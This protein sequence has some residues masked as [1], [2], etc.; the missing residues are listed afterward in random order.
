MA[1]A[2]MR[3]LL[4]A[5]IHFGHQTRRWHPKMQRFIFGQR[6]G[7]YI[8]DLQ[9]TLRR[10]Y[11]SYAL[12][13]DTVADGGTVLFV[14][15]KKQ[16]QEP[17]EREAKRC[18]MYFMTNRWLGGTLTN[19]QTVQRSIQELNH[20]KELESS[21]RI[22]RYSKKE[23]IQFRKR[24]EKL[25]KNLSGIADMPGLP[26]VIFVVDTKREEIA[27]R[28]AERLNIPCIGIVDTN[29]DPDMVNIAIPGNDDAIRSIGLFCS[30]I[31]DAVMEGRMF[32]SKTR[33]EEE[34]ERASRRKGGK[35][36]GRD[37]DAAMETLRPEGQQV[38]NVQDE[39]AAV[40]EEGG[41]LAG[42]E[43]AAAE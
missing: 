43:A 40:V 38:T 15:T 24:R 23:G 42:A 35:G 20:L 5:G 1:I 39:T 2:T 37:K 28:E 19:F 4:E 17:V 9:H 6:N 31:A 26:D 12:V 25:E 41:D 30:V 11:K 22:E 21:G 14:G 27:V 8:I 29:C 33:E 10:L 16:A 36:E 18:G 3:Q 7:I 13:R 34:R 32:Y